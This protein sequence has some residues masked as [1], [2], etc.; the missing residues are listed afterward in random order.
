MITDFGEHLI[1]RYLAREVGD[2]GT[3]IGIGTVDTTPTASDTKLGFEVV[4]VPVEHIF[5]DRNV[6][7]V[8]FRGIL[9]S[10][11]EGSIYEIGLWSDDGDDMAGEYGDRVITD[12][13]EDEEEWSAG[14][15][16]AGNQRSGAAALVVTNTTSTLSGLDYDISENMSDQLSVAGHFTANIAFSVRL[17]SDGGYYNYSFTPGG[18]GYRTPTVNMS[19]HIVSGAPDPEAITY[20]SVVVPSGLTVSFDAIRI[21]QTLTQNIDYGLVMRNVGSPIA[22]KEIGK[23]STIE[24]PF[25]I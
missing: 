15:F 5:L 1:R 11:Y 20:I 9:P 22:I 17:G 10:D 3:A 2:I 18:T 7:S 14:T 23:E 24:V 8:V 12:F 13:S 25:T 16:T 4:R 21:D 6:D 19:A